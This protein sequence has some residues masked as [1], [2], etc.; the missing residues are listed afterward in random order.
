MLTGAEDLAPNRRAFLS[1]VP[2]ARIV[3]KALLGKLFRK[4]VHRGAD[5]DWWSGR[6]IAVGRG[7]C[8]CTDLINV[9]VALSIAGLLP[10][11]ASGDD[12]A[13]I[14]YIE[15]PNEDWG[16]IRARRRSI[17]VSLDSRE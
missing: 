6:E 4:A 15:N 16:V 3:H 8:F 14:R 5:W 1:P 2:L 7:S 12:G 9:L 10:E 11:G 17:S 13:T